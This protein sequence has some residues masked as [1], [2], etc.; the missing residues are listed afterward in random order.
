MKKAVFT[1]ALLA[2][3]PLAGQQPV[4]QIDLGVLDQIKDQAFNHSQVLE[5]LFYIS[6]VYGPRINGSPNHRAAVSSLV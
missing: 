1:L 3:L 2:A 5:H 6:D 4:E